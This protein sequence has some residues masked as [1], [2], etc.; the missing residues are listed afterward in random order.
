MNELKNSCRF[1]GRLG[2]DPEMVYLPSGTAKLNF[3]LAVDN[4]RKTDSGSYEKETTWVDLVAFGKSAE[5]LNKMTQKGTLVA[6][7]AQYSK[8][9]WQNEAGENRVS[10]NFM[11]R[12]WELLK[13]GR[14][15]D[16]ATQAEDTGGAD[17]G[18]E[19]PF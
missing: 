19:F 7:D 6:V 2:K 1:M 9:H 8:G 18:E 10:H 13:D 16:D 4:R 5:N 12:S 14:S 11:V 15:K 3:S 17:L